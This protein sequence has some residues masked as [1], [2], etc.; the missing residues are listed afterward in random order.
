[1]DTPPSH[2]A[3]TPAPSELR[4]RTGWRRWRGLLLAAAALFVVM[5][6]SARPLYRAAKLRYARYQAGQAEKHI[7]KKDWR[8]AM[9]ALSSAN[10]FGRDDA[11]VLRAAATFL[12]STSNDPR[13]LILILQKLADTGNALPT[14]YLALGQA[15][16]G[17][18]ELDEARRIYSSLDAGLKDSREGIELLAQIQRG[19]GRHAEAEDTLRRALLKEPNV[20]E[21]K[22]RLALMDYGNNFPEVQNRGRAVMWEVVATQSDTALAAIKVLAQDRNLTAPEA[23]RLLQALDAHP[24]HP[25]SL[26]LEVLSAIIRISPHERDAVFAAEVDR[27]KDKGLAQMTE[28]ISWLAREQQHAMI[29]RLVP[30]EAALKSAEIFPYV[31]QALGEE[32]RW[33]DLRRLLTG[34]S[35]LPVSRARVQVWLAQAAIQLEPNDLDAPREHLES[36]FEMAVKADDYGSLAAASQVAE[37]RGL[38]DM[39]L[40]CY[41]RLAKASPRVEIEMTEKAREMALRLRDTREMMRASQRLVELRPASEAFR[42]DLDYLRL[43]SGEGM[44]LAGHFQRRPGS[45]SLDETS[46]LPAPFLRALSAYRFNEPTVLREEVERAASLPSNRFSIGQRAVLAGLMARAGLTSESFRLAETVSETVLLPE[47]KAIFAAA[48]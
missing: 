24:Q 20:P 42:D 34:G 27:Y 47:E 22:L 36:A 7:A 40:R 3:E 8:A 31:A 13:S 41:E 33:A 28:V 48:R 32:G 26:R 44:E 19:E 25:P 6:F 16:I 23:E 11:I 4:S 38:Y 21:S 37:S 18:G 45:L 15:H 39:A 43:L 35:S 14:D 30:T 5:L 1:M 29:L 9:L 10:R 17:L 12:T 2:P 46:S